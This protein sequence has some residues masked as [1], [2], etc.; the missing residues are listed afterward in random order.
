VLTPPPDSVEDSAPELHD[1]VLARSAAH[2]R[3]LLDGG[4]RPTKAEAAARLG[5]SPRTITRLV[6]A[7]REARV[8]IQEEKDGRAK[9]FFLADEHQRRGLRLDSFDEAMALALTV[10]AEAARPVLAGTPLEGALRRAERA[11]LDAASGIEGGLGPASFDPEEEPARWHFGPAAAEALDPE[12]FTA[13]R[14]A[15]TEGR[16]I[17]A[18]YLNKQGRRSPDRALSPLALGRVGGTWQLAAYCHERREVRNFNLTRLTNVRVLRRLAEPPE[19]FDARAHFT[20]RFGSLEGKGVP[21]EVRLRVS[22]A[23]AVH[24][25]AR[26]YHPSQRLGERPDGALT[27]HYAVPGGDALDEVRAFVASWGPHVVVEAP[28][29]LAARLAADAR[30]TAAAYAAKPDGAAP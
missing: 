5:L 20:G 27:A 11:L 17:R 2:F 22:A 3:R 26:R 12:T 14:R 28:P 30:A 25:R 15:I 21:V 13:V 6:G 24:F 4:L 1:D 23:R 29:E 18:E 9:R 7:L 8:P 19:G 10:A 16:Q